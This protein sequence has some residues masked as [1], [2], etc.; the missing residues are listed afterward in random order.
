MEFLEVME[1][2]EFGRCRICRRLHVFIVFLTV[3]VNA[4]CHGVDSI[5]VIIKESKYIQRLASSM[6]EIPSKIIPSKFLPRFFNE[7][8]SN[9]GGLR[10]GSRDRGGQAEE[11]YAIAR[12]RTEVEAGGARVG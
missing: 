11:D 6:S 9:T 10:R 3:T 12:A 2:V 4:V 8:T 7:L 1:D 5:K